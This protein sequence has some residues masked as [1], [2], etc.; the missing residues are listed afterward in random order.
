MSGRSRLPRRAKAGEHASP[1]VSAAFQQRFAKDI[2]LL[3]T[4][5]RHRPIPGRPSTKQQVLTLGQIVGIDPLPPPSLTADQWDDIKRQSVVRG[6]HMLPCAICHEHFKTDRQVLLSCSHTFHLDCL[7]SFERFSGT[8]TC[9]MCRRTDYEKIQ[10][11]EG[12]TQYRALC[13]TKIQSWYRGVVARRIVRHLYETVVPR[14]PEQK[15]RF[16]LRKLGQATDDIVMQTTS[17]SDLDAL[18]TECDTTLHI[19]RMLFS[20]AEGVLSSVPDAVDWDHLRTKFGD[21]IGDD[22]PICV[23]SMQPGRARYITSC[24]HIFHERCLKAFEEFSQARTCCPMC[25]TTDYTKQLIR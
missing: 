24:G 23:M 8:R 9:P 19:S 12:R 5:G 20:E 6:D 18:L 15:R 1:I 17:T 4:S 2:A 16:L 11:S 10:I 25:R 3:N 14:D 22:C 7:R 21:G 13:A